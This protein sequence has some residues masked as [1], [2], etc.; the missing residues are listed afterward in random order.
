MKVWELK[1]ILEQY[2]ENA[3]L[4]ILIRDSFNTPNEWAKI[5]LYD[6]PWVEKSDKK[7]WM[8]HRWID[9]KIN[10]VNMHLSLNEG[11]LYEGEKRV[12]LTYRK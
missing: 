6:W 11:N 9:G 5:D 10:S 1:K 3:E 4:N 8:V 12:K 7:L 2:P